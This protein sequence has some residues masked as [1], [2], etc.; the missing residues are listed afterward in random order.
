MAFK[1]IWSLT[2]KFDLHDLCE[3]IGQDNPS[4]AR[5]RISD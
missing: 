2:A 4:A 3:Y 1:L 5:L